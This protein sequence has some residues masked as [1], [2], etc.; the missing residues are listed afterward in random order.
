MKIVIFVFYLKLVGLT[1]GFCSTTILINVGSVR[2][3]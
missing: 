1:R 3:K 2:E